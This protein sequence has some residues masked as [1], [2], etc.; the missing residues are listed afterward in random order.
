[1]TFRE[2]KDKLSR[3]DRRL[4][5]VPGPD[6][7]SGVYIKG[8]HK[9][10]DSNPNG[11]LLIGCIPSPSWFLTLPRVDFWDEDRQYHR[12]WAKCLRLIVDNGHL[13][14]SRVKSVFGNRWRWDA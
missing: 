9:N 13:I 1:M 3:V 2:F 11:Y 12:G 6:K 8:Q 14:E 5:I 4:V 7:V 10:P